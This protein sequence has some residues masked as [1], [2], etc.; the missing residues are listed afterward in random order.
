MTAVHDGTLPPS[1][2]SGSSP[3]PPAAMAAPSFRLGVDSSQDRLHELQFSLAHSHAARGTV[4]PDD[5]IDDLADRMV[6][7]NDDEWKEMIAEEIRHIN[8][9]KGMLDEDERFIGGGGGPCAEGGISITA[10]DDDGETLDSLVGLMAVH[11]VDSID[12]VFDNRQK[13]AKVLGNYVMGDVLGEGSYAKVKEA[14]DQRTLCRR[15]VKIMKRRKLRRIPHGEE[16][17]ESEIR[18][19]ASLDHKNVMKLIEVFHNEEKG[20]IYIV[21]EYCCAVLKDMLDASDM[22]RFPVWQAHFYFTQLMDGLA[23]LHS[24]RIIHKDIKPGN[25]LLDTAGT[26]KIA[27]FGVAEILDRFALDDTCR[28]SQGTP[29][30]QPPEIA[31]GH[32]TFSGFKVDIW[33]T[34]VTLFNFITGTYPF[35]GDTIFR[36]FESIGK[37]EFTVPSDVDPLL[38]SLMRGMLRFEP[39]ERFSAADVMAH[40]WFR[41]RHPCN[42]PPVTVKPRGD[43]HALSTSVIPYLCDLHFGD[44]DDGEPDT[45]T[46]HELREREEAEAAARAAAADGDGEEEDAKKRRRKKEKTTRCIAVKK[47]GDCVVS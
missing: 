39:P 24:N 41:K 40:D 43:D 10:G 3:P 28:T 2:G 20:K 21:L 6:S 37:G 9:D 18:L 42:A 17:A 8:A 44:M 1:S 33:S 22:K 5:F 30:F 7:A 35:E 14:I 38:E 46:E 19:L 16:N 12:V 47:M 34:G 32:E 26:L 36:L 27:D 29:T 4:D 13:R 25:L 23:Y 15:A 11:R 31:N 45:V